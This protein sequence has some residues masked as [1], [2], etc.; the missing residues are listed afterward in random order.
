[1]LGI[2]KLEPPAG[3]KGRPKRIGRGPGSGHGKTATRGHKGAKS[4][5]GTRRRPGFEGGQMP[6]HRRLPRRGF[7]NIFKKVYAVVNVQALNAFA[8][9]SVVTPLKLKETGI[10]KNIRDGVKV[11]GEGEVTRALTVQA[12][13]FSRSARAKIEAA[14]GRAEVISPQKG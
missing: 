11:L 1:M 9:G 6:L 14:G 5:S 4:R 8:A 13:G 12:H 3:A 7:T 2:N 10:I